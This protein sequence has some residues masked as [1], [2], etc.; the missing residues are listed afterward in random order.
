MRQKESFKDLSLPPRCPMMLHAT[1]QAYDTVQYGT[2]Q[3]PA[4][5]ISSHTQRDVS[6]CT[7]CQDTSPPCHRAGAGATTPSYWC[8]TGGVVASCLLSTVLLPTSREK[9]D[10]GRVR[11]C[12][13]S[14]GCQKIPE[15][16]IL[17]LLQKVRKKLSATF[18]EFQE[19][20]VER[21]VEILISPIS[22]CIETSAFCE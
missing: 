11:V 13:S 17:T 9:Q 1:Y 16:R 22:G 4:Q 6:R 2:V 15:V 10:G 20:S 12:V 5:P 21:S 19:R 18:E 14:Y 7:P 8:I 3:S